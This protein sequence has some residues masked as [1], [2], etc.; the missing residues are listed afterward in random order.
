MIKLKSG[1][2]YLVLSAEFCL[3]NLYKIKNISLEKN[4]IEAE[5]ILITN[6]T[7]NYRDC[8]YVY[9]RDYT[10]ID[11]DQFLS[12]IKEKVPKIIWYR[13]IRRN[14]IKSKSDIY[15]YEQFKSW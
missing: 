12:R 5:R 3:H 9:L 10:D 6:Y 7:T 4:A 11:I 8:H 2:V 13:V 14:I 15:D 1:D